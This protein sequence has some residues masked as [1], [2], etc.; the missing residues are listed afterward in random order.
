MQVSKYEPS[1]WLPLKHLKE[2]EHQIQSGLVIQNWQSLYIQQRV[3]GGGAVLRTK[4]I[5]IFNFSIF[6]SC[7]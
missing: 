6:S 3:I 7:F 2:V 5:L 4:A 1:Y